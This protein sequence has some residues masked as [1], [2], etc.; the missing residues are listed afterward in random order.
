LSLNPVDGEENWSLTLKNKVDASPLIIGD[1]VVAA[2]TDGRM[3][4]ID[5]DSGQLLWQK[6]FNGSF[7]GSPAFAE[8]RIIIATDEGVVYCLSLQK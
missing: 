8:D 2:T 1:R 6:E 7:V 3:Y 5:R 4:V